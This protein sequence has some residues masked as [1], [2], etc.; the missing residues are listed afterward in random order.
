MAVV[1]LGQCMD[2]EFKGFLNANVVMPGARAQGTG[3]EDEGKENR[4]FTSKPR[5]MQPVDEMSKSSNRGLS[6]WRYPL[7]DITPNGATLV[8]RPPMSSYV[9]LLLP[10]LQLTVLNSRLV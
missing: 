2:N 5:L 7:V 1:V 8:V 4:F 10:Y 9:W 6:G 3:S